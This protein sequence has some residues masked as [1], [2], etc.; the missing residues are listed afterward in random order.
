MIGEASGQRRRGRP[1]GLGQTRVRGAEVRDRPDQIPAM[2][3]GQRAARE[4]PAAARQRRQPLTERG[5]ES[6]DVRGV[7]HPIS[8][9]ATPERLDAC[10]RAL[11]DAPLDVNDTSRRRAFH[12]LGDADLAPPP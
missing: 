4:R 11:H 6:R 2:L 5:V 7:D 8:L 3:Q 9:R 10:G 12:D 1:P